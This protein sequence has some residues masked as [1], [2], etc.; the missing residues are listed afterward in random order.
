MKRKFAPKKKNDEDKAPGG[1]P[2]RGGGAANLQKETIGDTAGGINVNFDIPLIVNPN[3][4]G[5]AVRNL[6]GASGMGKASSILAG[7]DPGKLDIENLAAAIEETCQFAID[8]ESTNLDLKIFGLSSPP[9]PRPTKKLFS[10]GLAAD[11]YIYKHVLSGT[12]VVGP[13]Y[14]KTQIADSFTHV[15]ILARE[16]GMVQVN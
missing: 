4:G 12:Q 14:T 8:L 10:A 6:D 2:V 13:L 9:D 15:E 1:R 16:F 3:S 7:G 5:S 11:K